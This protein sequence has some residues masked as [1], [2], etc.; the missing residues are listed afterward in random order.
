MSSKQ[1]PC[2]TRQEFIKSWLLFLTVLHSSKDTS[3]QHTKF[4]PLRDMTSTY[5][6]MYL[7]KCAT[8]QSPPLPTPTP[9]MYNILI[10]PYSEVWNH[11]F[12]PLCFA[13]FLALHKQQC[14]IYKETIVYVK[15][16]SIYIA[17]HK[18]KLYL[19]KSHCS[20]L[21]LGSPGL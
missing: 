5:M 3:T 20:S 1:Q 15:L 13:D 2:G 6:Y 19:P 14:Q 8:G 16:P 10:K 21:I 4:Q 18:L 17:P 11:S 7:P 12:H 9:Q